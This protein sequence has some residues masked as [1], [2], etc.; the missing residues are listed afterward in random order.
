MLRVVAFAL[1]LAVA[2]AAYIPLGYSGVYDV[3]RSYP[4]RDEQDRPIITT[5]DKFAFDVRT[6]AY[7][8][9]QDVPVVPAV[10]APV[11]YHAA[12]PVAY[13]AGAYHA[14][15]VGFHAGAYA[16]PF[17]GAGVRYL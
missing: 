16:A 2:S 4:I 12:A 7:R 5:G 15:P 13:A 8:T 14:A 3:D 11:A 9:D 10:A 1:V 17:Y 6:K